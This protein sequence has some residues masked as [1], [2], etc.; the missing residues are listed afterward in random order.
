MASSS[1]TF[2]TGLHQGMSLGYF[3]HRSEVLA[4][5]QRSRD[6]PLAIRAVNFDSDELRSTV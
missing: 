1:N 4:T 5:S 3:S 2:V 6:R